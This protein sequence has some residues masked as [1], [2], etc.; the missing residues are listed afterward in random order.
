MS[1][2]TGLESSAPVE[3]AAGQTE[4]LQTNTR[5]L[6]WSDFSAA[7]IRVGTVTEASLITTNQLSG[8][9]TAYAA[10][11]DF[12]GSIGVQKA[13]ALVDSK[14]FPSSAAL[15]HKQ[16]LAVTNVDVSD[17]GSAT[18]SVLSVGGQALL[19]PAKPVA[20]GYILA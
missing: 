3:F 15:L 19:Q 13:H 12:G 9:L 5:D 4:Q 17:D 10:L 8:N 6:A 2:A 7:S 14:V 1:F 11:M 20:N 18:V 16:L